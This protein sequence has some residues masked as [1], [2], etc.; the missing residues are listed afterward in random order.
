MWT[1]RWKQALGASLTWLMLAGT[2]HA[3]EPERR[4]SDE[5]WKPIITH[6]GVAF[7]YIFYSEADNVNNGVVVRLHN[8]NAYPIRYRFR[9]VFRTWRGEEHVEPVT[10]VLEAGQMKTGE[11]DGLF[12]IPFR[13]GRSVGEVGLRGY[14]IEPIRDG[15]H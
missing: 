9:I 3:Q 6:N 10:G 12:W 5:V 2:V 4:W 11:Q 15:V 14:A 13:D 8:R 1:T 7:A